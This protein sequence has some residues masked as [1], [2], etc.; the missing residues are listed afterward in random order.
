MIGVGL[1]TFETGLEIVHV[2]Q[3]FVDDLEIVFDVVALRWVIDKLLD[4]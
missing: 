4:H 3:V 1:N 2:S